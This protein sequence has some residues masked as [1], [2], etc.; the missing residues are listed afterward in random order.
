MPESDTFKEGTL[1][2][3][4]ACGV[5]P[6]TLLR[7]R[8][9]RVRTPRGGKTVNVQSDRALRP[10][11]PL[12]RGIPGAA[13]GKE[14][15]SGKCCSV[16][17]TTCGPRRPICIPASQPALLLCLR[18]GPTARALFCLHP[19]SQPA[20]LLCLRFGS[21]DR[22]VLPAPDS[23]T[24]PESSGDLRRRLRAMLR[25]QSRRWLKPMPGEDDILKRKLSPGKAMVCHDTTVFRQ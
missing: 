15:L 1:T 16:F 22:A 10:P 14:L 4:A 11:F 13:R 21:A 12:S 9:C 3:S 24:V 8:R 18:F 2:Q 25:R 23:R 7:R 19:D 6:Q 5:Y 17:R 20:L